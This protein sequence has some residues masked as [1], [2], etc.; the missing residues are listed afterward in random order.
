MPRLRLAACAALAAVLGFGAINLFYV[1]FAAAGWLRARASFGVGL[2][3]LF[4]VLRS[5]FLG[6]LENPEPRYTLEGFPCAILLASA[7]FINGRKHAG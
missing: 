7:L 6:T 2:V 1:G 3:I 4:I 5:G